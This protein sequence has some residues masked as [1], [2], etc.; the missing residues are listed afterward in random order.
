MHYFTLW[1]IIGA[2]LATITFIAPI[3]LVFLTVKA[4]IAAFQNRGVSH[5]QPVILPK[6]MSLA[7]Q[8]EAETGSFS[9]VARL[10]NRVEQDAKLLHRNASYR[11]MAPEMVARE[12]LEER[13]EIPVIIILPSCQMVA[14]ALTRNGEYLRLKLPALEA[15]QR[16]QESAA[17]EPVVSEPVATEQTPRTDPME[18]ATQPTEVVVQEAKTE[19]T[20][21]SGNEN[22]YEM[23]EP[24]QGVNWKPVAA[25]WVR[26]NQKNIEAKAQ[27]AMSRNEDVIVIPAYEL[28]DLQAWSAICETLTNELGLSDVEMEESLIRARF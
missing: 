14:Q 18:T 12:L 3:V 8:Y 23:Y 13:A 5:P 6:K 16:D 1:S 22:S 28:P 24:F 11:F 7:G 26:E 2:V 10:R 17:M 9:R 20:E 15:E 27:E 25:R 4:I 21:D 19:S